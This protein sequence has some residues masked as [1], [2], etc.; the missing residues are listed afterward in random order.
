[1]RRIAKAALVAPALALSACYHAV[2]ET[3]R[4]AGSTVVTKRFQPGFVYGLVPPPPLN[5]ATEC[6]SGVAKVET[7]HSFVEGLVAG[8]TFGLFTPMSY[9]V[10]CASGGS[11]A[12]PAE[13]TI[14]VG[15]NASAEQ[16]GAAVQAAA[17]RAA[18]TGEAM[19]VR[20]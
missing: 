5:V 2:V 8:L 19:F 16:Q 13:R 17:E 4:P 3:G 15:A 1:M 6:P 18:A 20:F 10:T 14:E 12:I 11:S 9:I 7:E